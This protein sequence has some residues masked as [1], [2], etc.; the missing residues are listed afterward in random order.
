MH[1]METKVKTVRNVTEAQEQ[2]G[3]FRL[4]G[5]R[6][7]QIYVLAYDKDRTDRVAERT[8]AEQIGVMEEGFGTA[9]ANVFRSRDE[10][11]RAKLRSM[12]F[13]Q[14]DAER[15]EMEMENDKIIVIAWGGTYYEGNDY[16]P[17][18]YYYPPML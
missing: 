3:K 10:E 11:L 9:I 12:G 17:S 5:Y 6:D 16:D 14:A 18:I 15:L 2:V 8:N 7:D 1:T 4:D 13:I